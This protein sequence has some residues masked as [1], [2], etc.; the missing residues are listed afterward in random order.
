MELPLPLLPPSLG[1]VY[2]LDEQVQE[3]AVLLT[4]A[5]ELFGDGNCQ[6][7]PRWLASSA[8]A[9]SRSFGVAS[10]ADGVKPESMIC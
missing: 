7:R 8:S 5:R 2:G 4:R 9:V 6:F 3:L 1:G 10:S